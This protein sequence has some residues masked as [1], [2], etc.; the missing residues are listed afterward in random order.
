MRMYVGISALF[1]I[2][3]RVIVVYHSWRDV[4]AKRDTLQENNIILGSVRVSVR[5]HVCLC[6]CVSRKF[7]NYTG[8]LNYLNRHYSVF[9]MNN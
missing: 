2:A 4:Y 8:E 6:V 3:M 1:F 7:Y 9:L 5:V